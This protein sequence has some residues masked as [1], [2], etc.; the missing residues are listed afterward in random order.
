MIL[1][2]AGLFFLFGNGGFSERNVSVK[3]DGPTEIAAGELAEYKVSYKNKNKVSLI[4]SRLILYYPDDA[5]AIKDENVFEGHSVSVDLG[6][7]TPNGGGEYD[8]KGYLVGDR[9]NI[10]TA[11]VVL[12][13]SV[14]SISPVLEKEDQL[15]TT[16]T[17]LSVPLTLVAPPTAENGQKITYILDYRNQSSQDQDGLRVKFTYPSGFKPETYSPFPTS[18]NDTWDIAKLVQLSG[19]RI[20]ITGTIS[21]GERD[22]KAVSVILQR[23]ISTPSGEQYVDYEKTEASTAISSPTISI[24]VSV[25]NSPNYTAHLGDRL[26]YIVQVKNNSK[27]NILSLTLTAQLEGNMY[28]LATVKAD[29]FLDSRTR[30]V[31]WNSSVI[32]ALSD[33]KPGQSVS[34]PVTVQ[35]KNSFTSGGVNDSFV[36]LSA[37]LETSSVPSELAVDKL[38]ADGDLITRISTAATFDQKVLINDPLGA[39]GPFPVKV[40]QK[41]SFYIHWILTNPTNAVSSAKITAVLAPGIVW[42]NVTRVNGSQPLPKYDS[43]TNTVTW[44]IV[45]LPSGVGTNFPAYEGVFKI[46]ITPSVNQVGESPP[47]LTSINFSGTDTFTKEKIVINLINTSVANVGDSNAPRTVQP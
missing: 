35:L 6:T 45:E 2:V 27:Y 3:I 5:V 37:H 13:F 21:G 43:R 39:E 33:L 29:G 28:D 20:S 44:N 30:I 26:Q 10:K 4:N 41:T 12:S 31:T 25:N 38:V 40:D 24:N 32:P 14:S 9:G 47:L 18:G 1:V 17:S 7:I 36:R 15:A 11:R 42:S 8:F 22:V 23:R 19:S 46:S 16:I 34:V